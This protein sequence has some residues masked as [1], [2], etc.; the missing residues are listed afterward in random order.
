M[1]AEIEKPIFIVS[2]PRSGS[3]VFYRK[4]ARHPD[5]AWIARATRKFPTSMA[6]NRLL[7]PFRK[8]SVPVEGSRIWRCF[9]REEDDALGR[10]DLTP[11]ARRY[12]RRLVETQTRLAR[13]SRFLSKYPRNGLRLAW[14]DGIFPDALFIHLVRDGRAVARSI[15][16]QR[17]R[18]GGREVWWG[19]RPPG[20]RELLARDPVEQAGLQW[21]LCIEHTRAAAATLGPG[22]YLEQRYEDFC[23]APAEVL[24]R[25]GAFCGLAWPEALL[26]EIV[27]DVRSQN[28][29]WRERL[30]AEEIEGM[31]KVAGDLLKDVGYELLTS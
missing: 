22:R 1:S 13:K 25:V 19:S 29:K 6:M 7:G 28:Y 17:D 26:E 27:G 20:W 11:A 16:E 12:V 24:R 15:L 21:K 9:A 14:L 5:L 10:E 3:W 18:H 4:L 23:E 30:G 2:L 31:E 8:G